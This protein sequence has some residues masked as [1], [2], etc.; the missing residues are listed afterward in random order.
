MSSARR[1]S[2][3]R[4]TSR[5]PGGA[6]GRPD[7]PISQRV[8]Q[9]RGITFD[10]AG[11]LIEPWP[12]VGEIYSQAARAYGWSAPSPAEL[13]DAFGRAWQKKGRFDYSPESWAQLV[14]ETFGRAIPAR[15]FRR[16][17]RAFEGPGVWRV[18]EDVI[19]ALEQL[20][21][22]GFRLGI[23]SNWD[24]RLR[25]LLGRLGLGR[26]F[27]TILISAEVGF[28]KPDPR[29]FRAAGKALGIA[30]RFLLHIGDQ[31]NE[32]LAGAKAAG[33]AGLQIVRSGKRSPGALADLW[34]LLELLCGKAEG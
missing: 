11:T 26:Y 1:K 14:A 32:D 5:P 16:L 20:G 33:W 13:N 21:Q 24:E 30:P 3:R 22:R 29:I 10:A 19:P 4:A 9:I 6:T 18:Y 2:A 34:E 7:R 27:Q 23:I 17:Y 28:H 15:F 25:P 8:A 31:Q 12:S